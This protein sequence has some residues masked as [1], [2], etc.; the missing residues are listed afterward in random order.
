MEGARRA[1]DSYQME[2]SRW[3]SGRNVLVFLALVGWV[4]CAAGYATS[5][6][7]F[8]R[9]YLVAFGFTITVS[10]AAFFFVQ[11][12]FLTGSAWSV[13]LR[14]LMEN[15]MVV[16]PVGILLFIPVA[17]GLH[18]LYEWTH[19]DVVNADPILRLKQSYLNDQFFLIRAGV[20]L[21]LWSIWA[22][23]IHRQSTKQ[24]TERSIRQMHAASRWSAPGLLL[25]FVGGT[26]AAFDWFM[27]LDPH[28]YSTIFGVYVLAG[29]AG[30]FWGS[31]TLICLSF[32]SA[33]L[34]RN[35][36]TVE[37]YHDLGKW[38]FAMTVFYAYIGFSQYMLIWYANLPEEVGWFLKRRE[39]TWA[40]VSVGLI[41]GKF[42]IPFLG[43]LCRPAKRNL[44]VLGFFAVWLMVWHYID[45]YWIIM[46]TWYKAGVAFHWLDVA[47][48]VA[49][50]STAGLMFW[51]RLR[52]HSMMPI[53]DLRF[54]QGL[55][56]ENA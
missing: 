18:D 23:N 29:G 33:G 55:R 20:Y 35:S 11:V 25:F 13:P 17:L 30:A 15:V 53:G 6:E 34:L 31:M 43:L 2:S 28:W 7:R 51:S 1:Q 10:L 4:A 37:Q 22:L 48:L 5:P 42:I 19:A 46:P 36:I 44:K 12:Q 14:R 21:L 16:L 54:E 24:D 8:F 39:G 49:A 27:S 3:A 38:M 52:K 47:T 50:L 56:F 9:S 26:L 32:R 45:M 41:F 40:W